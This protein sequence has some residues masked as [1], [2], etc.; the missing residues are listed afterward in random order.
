MLLTFSMV[1]ILFNLNKLDYPVKLGNDK[2]ERLP[3][4]YSPDND[5]SCSPLASPLTL[6]ASASRAI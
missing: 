1:Y 4:I 6:Y 3:P 2:W 5:W